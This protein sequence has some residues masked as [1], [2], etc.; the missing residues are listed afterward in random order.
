MTARPD[1]LNTSEKEVVK[2]SIEVA[3]KTAQQE[4]LAGTVTGEKL[5]LKGSTLHLMGRILT[6]EQVNAH[7]SAPGAPYSLLVRQLSDA[8][9]YDMLN[10]AD[11]KIQIALRE[12]Q[13]L[14]GEY[15]GAR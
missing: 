9:K 15:L 10:G 14:L 6:T 1:A 5:A 3:Y 7:R 4:P 11:K 2:L 12:L 13:E 8:I